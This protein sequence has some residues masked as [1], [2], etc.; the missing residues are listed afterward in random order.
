MFLI[1]CPWCGRRDQGEF[2]CGG[3]AHIVRPASPDDLDD[4]SWADYLFNRKNPKGVHLEQWVHIQGCGRWFNA[5]RNTVSNK[6]VS[7]Y[8]VGEEPPHPEKR[9]PVPESGQ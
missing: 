2:S 5:A 3:E 9:K 7:V 1:E 8:K 4:E 6:I